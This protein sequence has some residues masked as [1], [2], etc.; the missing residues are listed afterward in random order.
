MIFMC[1]RFLDTIDQSD[2]VIHWTSDE[3]DQMYTSVRFVALEKS[4]GV[5]FSGVIGSMTVTYKV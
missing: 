5:G 3:L 1:R 2:L 4:S